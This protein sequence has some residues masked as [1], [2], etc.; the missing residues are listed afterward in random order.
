[1]KPFVGDTEFRS[2]EL[3]M[4]LDEFRNSL[5]AEGLP[6]GLTPSLNG[7]WC[8]GKSDWA[9]AHESAQQD[10]GM[11]GSWVHTYPH[12]K[13]G[14]QDNAAYWYGRAGKPVCREPLDAEW[15]SIAGALLG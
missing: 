1:M 12:R 6:D 10:E 4:T 9:R 8:D 3:T 7:L 2:V 5:K 13:E 15:V 14:D 11:E